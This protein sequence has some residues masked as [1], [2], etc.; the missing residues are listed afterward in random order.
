M[1]EGTVRESG[2]DVDTWL[3]L[4]WTCWTAQGT[5]L[6]ATWQPGREGSLGRMG[7]CVCVAE[8]LPIYLELSQH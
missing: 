1:G 4:T 8:S 6:H 7:T 2:M 5:L 3:C